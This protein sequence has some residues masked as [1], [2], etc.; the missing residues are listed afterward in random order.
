VTTLGALVAGDG[1]NLE[2]DILAKY[3][4]ALIRKRDV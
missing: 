1:V 3:I 2:A 4:E